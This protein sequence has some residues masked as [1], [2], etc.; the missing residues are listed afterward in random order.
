LYEEQKTTDLDALDERVDEEEVDG[1]RQAQEEAGVL[2]LAE[3]A[4]GPAGELAEERQQV[5]LDVVAQL[6]RAA[7]VEVA[8]QHQL[9]HQ[10]LGPPQRNT[11]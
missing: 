5:L 1:A 4:L 9:L 10:K 6:R 11:T 8:L 2:E 3:V 7:V